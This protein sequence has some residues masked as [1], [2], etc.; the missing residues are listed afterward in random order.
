MRE[1][2]KAHH[3]EDARR[4]A[5]GRSKRTPGSLSEQTRPSRPDSLRGRKLAPRR[6]RK[7]GQRRSRAP[8]VGDG[9]AGAPG[10]GSGSV[11]PAPS[12]PRPG[13]SFL[14]ASGWSEARG[15]FCS[16]ARASRLPSYFS[17]L[18]PPGVPRLGGSLASGFETPPRKL[19]PSSIP[20]ALEIHPSPRGL[21]FRR[22]CEPDLFTCALDLFTCELDQFTWTL[23]LCDLTG[24]WG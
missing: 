6:S 13:R 2:N 4:A 20:F 17:P 14:A 15:S 9:E 1:D 5:P 10:L 19:R 3:P 11:H 8:E 24:V 21:T 23:L 7:P 12:S 22:T 18:P 16:S